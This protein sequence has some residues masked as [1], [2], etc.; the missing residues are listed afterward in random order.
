MQSN[1]FDPTYG[2]TVDT[3]TTDLA[4]VVPLFGNNCAYHYRPWLIVI[5]SVVLYQRYLPFLLKAF[6]WSSIATSLSSTI[7]QGPIHMIQLQES[8]RNFAFGDISEDHNIVG[9]PS[10]PPPTP[11][12]THSFWD[13]EFDTSTLCLQTTLT[14]TCTLINNWYIGVFYYEHL[15]AELNKF[16]KKV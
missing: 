12:I 4:S 16:R 11:H 10:P 1:P 9:S 7:E 2:T 6:V 8:L 13:A 3:P 15:I 14:Y 5:M